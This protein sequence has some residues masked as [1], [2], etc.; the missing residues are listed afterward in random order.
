MET[1]FSLKEQIST[2]VR[3]DVKYYFADLSVFISLNNNLLLKSF[4]RSSNRS[5][6]P[7]NNFPKKVPFR[8]V[9]ICG[10]FNS[11]RMKYKSAG[12]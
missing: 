8:C 4:R 2:E 3:E 7:R 12:D 10:D 9:Q 11:K 5:R 6:S 1:P